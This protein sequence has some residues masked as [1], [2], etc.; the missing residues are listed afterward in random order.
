M[1]FLGRTASRLL[2]VILE[3][4]STKLPFASNSRTIA[5]CFS[6]LNAS[7]SSVL[8]KYSRKNC[9]CSCGCNGLHTKGNLTVIIYQYIIYQAVSL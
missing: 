4:V 1:S 2:P 8:N 3:G 5:K 7:S 6:S 9:L